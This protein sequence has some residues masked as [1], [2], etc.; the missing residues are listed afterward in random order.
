MDINT[1]KSIIATRIKAESGNPTS[2]SFLYTIVQMVNELEELR[3]EN[4][5]L[6]SR[7]NNNA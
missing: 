6:K 5:E 3:A 7:L 2:T 1:L 4:A